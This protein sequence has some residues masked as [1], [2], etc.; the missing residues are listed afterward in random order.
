MSDQ[1]PELGLTRGMTTTTTPVAEPTQTPDEIVKSAI[2]RS[3]ESGIFEILKPSPELAAALH[4]VANRVEFGT[5]FYGPGGGTP[6]WMVVL[7]DT[8]APW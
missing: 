2:A 7:C 5:D 3:T 1:N 8:D 4:A 6:E